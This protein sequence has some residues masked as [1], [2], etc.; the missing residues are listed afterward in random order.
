MESLK[1][2]SEYVA[3]TD[4]QRWP[5]NPKLHDEAGLDASIERFGFT[6]PCIVDET[7]GKLVAGHGRGEALQRRF[8][9]GHPPPKNI[10][11]AESGWMVPVVRGVSFQND[12]EAESYLLADNRLTE[13]GGWDSTALEAILRS[14]NSVEAGLAGT[15]WS[16][17]EVELALRQD[18]PEDSDDVPTLPTRDTWVKNGDMFQL[19]G[20]RLLCGD[21]TNAACVS[22]L[23]GDERAKLM[24]TDPPYGVSYDSSD[25][26][27]STH[28]HIA[29]AND[30]L[31]DAA[32]QR[33]LESA[34][35]L[36]S[37]HALTVD[38]AWYL[39]HAHLTQGFF[40]AAAAAAAAEVLLHRQIIWVKKQ[41]IMG[42][43]QYHWKHEPC[44][45]GW[46]RGHVPHD[47]G[48]GSG[49]RDQTT[50]WEI[51]GV[52]TSE[53]AGLMHAT[54]KPVALFEIPI[55]KHTLVGEI[56]YEPFAGSGPQIIAA[57][58]L[59]RRCF[60]IEMEPLHVQT[61]IARWEKFTGSTAVKIHSAC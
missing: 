18:P 53:R 55:V 30:D 59:K 12:L 23:M 6:A 24:C 3:L 21:S 29:I 25:R 36:A 50:V 45:M 51:P 13:V 34:M 20:S 41:L 46:R 11:V 17:S 40:A 8:V 61:I 31:R 38:A 1:Y 48:R 39:W 35:A 2:R 10:V 27:G 49:E 44:F 43:G 58:R 57:E 5:R 4:I 28:K 7:S 16:A 52:S 37:T 42:R 32:L 60:A 33:F 22:L 56:V 19:G 15:G 26:V 14:I 9:A 47:Y 54:P